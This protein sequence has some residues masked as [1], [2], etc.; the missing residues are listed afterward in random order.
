MAWEHPIVWSNI[1]KKQCRIFE[2]F[3]YNLLCFR[4]G[5][6]GLTL[7]KSGSPVSLFLIKVLILFFLKRETSLND[8][9]LSKCLW[10]NWS[11]WH[12]LWCMKLTVTW[13]WW[14][15]YP[16]LTQVVIW[17]GHSNCG[18]KKRKREKQEG[19]STWYKFTKGW[20]I[21]QKVAL[22]GTLKHE[23]KIHSFRNLPLLAS[24]SSSKSMRILLELKS[25][26]GN[27][28]IH[29]FSKARGFPKLWLENAIRCLEYFNINMF[30]MK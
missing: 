10:P 30:C 18:K 27:P 23:K 1:Q 7:A 24:Y 2:T 13:Y 21:F 4:N 5:S 11:L 14:G 25:F 6:N 26:T 22:I 8:K 17:V 12:T 15:V 3:S 20:H 9:C 29:C 19:T 28:N 16:V